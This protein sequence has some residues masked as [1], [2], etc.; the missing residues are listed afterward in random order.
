[1]M[2][3][4]MIKIICIIMAALMVLS[5]FAV[6]LQVFALEGGVMT[7]VPVTGD[8]DGDYIIPATIAVVAVLAVGICLVLPKL[9]KK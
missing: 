7:Y 3:K 9:K 5:V 1:M 6:C 2:S 8:N 4:K